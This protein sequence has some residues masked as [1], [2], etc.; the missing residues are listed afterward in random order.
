MTAPNKM[1]KR[2]AAGTLALAICLTGGVIGA[3][4]ANAAVAN[5][6]ITFTAPA[7]AAV[8]KRGPA[9]DLGTINLVLPAATTF[10]TGDAFTVTAPTGF[11][12]SGT[13]VAAGTYTA[14]GTA[15][16][17]G[18]VS[19]AGSTVTFTFTGASDNLQAESFAITGLRGAADNT[20]TA[21]QASA[22]VAGLGSVIALPIAMIQSS[23]NVE[24]AN[25]VPTIAVGSTGAAAD[26]TIKDRSVAWDANDTLRLT[27]PAGQFFAAAPSVAVSNTAD[28]ANANIRLR[29]VTFQ[30]LNAANT[31][32]DANK[33]AAYD[34]IFV[35]A[36]GTGSNVN[37]QTPVTTS[38]ITLAITGLSVQINAGAPAAQVDLAF[39]KGKAT[40]TDTTPTFT[41]GTTNAAFFPDLAATVKIADSSSIAVTQTGTQNLITNGGA[42]LISPIR[43]AE[44]AGANNGLADG[45]YTLT[46]SNATVSDPNASGFKATVTGSPRLTTPGNPP[47]ITQASASSVTVN[48]TGTN[49]QAND[50]FDVSNL[51]ISP[52]GGN[53]DVTITGPNGVL[54]P[55]GK[56][57][58]IA[59]TATAERIGGLDRYATANQVATALKG[60]D[61]N[62]TDGQQAT[63]VDNIILAQGGLQTPGEQAPDALTANY[64]SGR[65]TVPG[66]GV[67]PTITAASSAADIAAYDASI[68]RVAP[69]LLTGKDVLPS[70]TL[71]AMT[72]AFG[73][74]DT[75]TN[76]Y[77][78]KTIT[79]VGGP[80]AV[81]DA[82]L[83]NLRTVLPG[84]KVV[85]VEG[86][87]RYATA[88]AVVLGQ[89]NN[90]QRYSPDYNTAQ[91]PTAVI[92]SGENSADALSAGP[93][94]AKV[95]LPLLLT[96]KDNL[97]DATKAALSSKG[98]GRVIVMGGTN[99]VSQNVEDQ[100]KALNITVQRFAGTDRYDTSAQFLTWA[101]TAAAT[102]TTPTKG[103][104]GLSSFDSDTVYLTNGQ[105]FADALVDGPLSAATNRNVVLT[106][107]AALPAPSAAFIKASNAANVV[108]IGLEGVVPTPVVNDAKKAANGP[109][110]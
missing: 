87:D 38:D 90:V 11:V 110:S 49:A 36:I 10:G 1:A 108:A 5:G 14:G 28:R 84:V 80:Q 18:V 94:T 72:M 52:T 51:Y 62:P 73:V 83:D 34:V 43:V 47:V 69:I 100:L 95:N 50:Y 15:T 41:A 58:T 109:L 6:T 78:S 106:T 104:L 71:Q 97:P 27:L 2:A 81:S 93:V 29:P 67:T 17:A 74:T 89:S 63:Q 16:L 98:I 86:A 33:I 91:V 4:A 22:T 9:A 26:V 92:A 35:D 31:G 25:T 53:V 64:L 30:Q 107:A 59:V 99:A 46:F 66:T 60:I 32:V 7:N 61:L 68:T 70:Y 44:V 45:A 65:K 102:S 103:G 13:P 39:A 54:L 105:K 21:G 42:Q 8:V 12:F 19:G 96:Q 37:G 82:V 79:V 24:V 57:A 23:S 48:I 88:A 20:A 101:K 85:R 75:G 76:A 55:T 56:V 3:G 77:A 40:G